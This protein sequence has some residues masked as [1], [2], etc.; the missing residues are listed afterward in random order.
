MFLDDNRSSRKRKRRA[1]RGR[2]R[3]DS[4][5]RSTK[6]KKRND[7]QRMY[8]FGAIALLFFVIIG[9][10]AALF[11]GVLFARDA[12]FVNDDRF[13][14]KHIEVVDGQIKTEAMI[15]EY[16]TY[17]GIDIGTNLFSFN[18][19]DFEKV[20]L[21]RNPLV[22]MIKLTRILPDTLRVVIQ[23]RDPLV[24][25]GQRGTLVTDSNGFVFRLSSNLHRLPV[26]VGC[27]DPELAPGGYVRG[28]TMRAVEVLA[29]CDNP[30]VGVRVLGIDVG[31][32]DFLLMHVLTPDGIKKARLD[33]D[34]WD[35][36]TPESRKNM[37]LRLSRLRQSIKN[38]RG[39]HSQYDATFPGRI[40]VR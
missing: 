35:K 40:N 25:L 32:K 16:L 37:K 5:M 23:E 13:K 7:S 4:R 21:K 34:D 29:Y 10:F 14:I 1:P 3:M 20:Y 11:A 27:K 26:I 33:W 24:R 2:Y 38:D 15:R 28:M 39:N 22:K 8:R 12:L 9:L 36:G 17:V 19:G 6:R 18:L 31:N 30:R